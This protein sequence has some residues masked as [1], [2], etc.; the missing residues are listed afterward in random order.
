M[1]RPRLSSN[2]GEQSS[3]YFHFFCVWLGVVIWAALAQKD[4]PFHGTC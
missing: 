4:F 1:A 3:F 2:H